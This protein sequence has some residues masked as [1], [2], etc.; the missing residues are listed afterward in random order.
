MIDADNYIGVR[1]Q[2]TFFE[3]Y[4]RV[5][6][7]FTKLGS[8]VAFTPVVGQVVRLEAEG[9]NIKLYVDTVLKRTEVESFNNT[10][11]NVGF[12]PRGG[13]GLDPIIDTW[14]SNEV[15]AVNLVPGLVSATRR[16]RG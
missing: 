13:G 5:P 3:I 15:S 1:P 9:N 16:A 6:G 11:L 4:K 10:I 12:H 2:S 7:S 8:S 14:N